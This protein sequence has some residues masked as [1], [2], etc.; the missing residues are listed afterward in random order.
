MKNSSYIAVP[1]SHPLSRNINVTIKLKNN[2]VLYG[3]E[4]WSNTFRQKRT[5]AV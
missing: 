2:V 1:S 3:C 5:E 4:N